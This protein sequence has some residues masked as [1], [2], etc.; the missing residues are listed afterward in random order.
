[1]Y[2]VALVG[3]PLTMM[4][5]EGPGERDRPLGSAPALMDH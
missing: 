4:S 1:M 3:V 5:P 2:G